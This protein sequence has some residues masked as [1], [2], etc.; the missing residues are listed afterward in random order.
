MA[1]KIV[2][3]PFPVVSVVKK[4]RLCG[5]YAW[6]LELVKQG[7]TPEQFKERVDRMEH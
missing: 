5:G 6:K 4:D 3:Y 7:E 2:V 1:N